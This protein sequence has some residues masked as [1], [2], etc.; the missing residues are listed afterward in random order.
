MAH[1][2]GELTEDPKLVNGNRYLGETHKFERPK[3]TDPDYQYRDGAE[4][5]ALDRDRYDLAVRFKA[6]ND[7]I[8]A[9]R[10]ADIDAKR[11]QA[12]DDLTA[13][14]DA[15]FVESLRRRYLDSDPRASEEDFQRDLGEIR[16]Q[17]RIAAALADPASASRGRL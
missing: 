12:K 14:R 2:N 10:S 1:P 3:A 16:R 5:F 6:E 7:E 17:S 9:R 8:K 15:R 11:Q 4:R 13:E